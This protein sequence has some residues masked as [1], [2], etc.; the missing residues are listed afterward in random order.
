MDFIDRNCWDISLLENYFTTESRQKN[1]SIFNETHFPIDKISVIKKPLQIKKDFISETEFM[2]SIILATKIKANKKIY[3]IEGET[4]SGKSELC[5]WIEYNLVKKHVPLLFTR[6]NTN[7]KQIFDKLSEHSNEDYDVK[8]NLQIYDTENLINYIKTECRLHY[9]EQKAK[10]FKIRELKG[11][12]LPYFRKIVENS[13]FYDSIKKN[14]LDYQNSDEK[15]LKSYEPIKTA[16]LKSIIKYLK[17]QLNDKRFLSFVAIV[18]MYLDNLFITRF[19]CSKDI[20]EILL[21]ICDKYEKEDKRIVLIFEDITSM[22]MYKDQIFQFIFDKE[23][24]NVD[25]IIGVTTGFVRE[26]KLKESTYWDRTDGYFS[27]SSEKG[28]TYFLEENNE[29]IINLT[30]KYMQAV[31]KNCEKCIEKSQCFEVFGEYLFP[32]TK[33]VLLKI[34]NNLIENNVPKRTPRLLLEKVQRKILYDKVFPF[35]NSFIKEISGHF[36]S[37]I[38][39]IN[40]DFV[41]IFD[42]FGRENEKDNEIYYFVDRNLFK[43]FSFDL[44]FENLKQLPLEYDSKNVYLKTKIQK[45]VRKEPKIDT[46]VSVD[47]NEKL[48]QKQRENFAK[49]MQDGDRFL[50]GEELRIGLTKLLSSKH[51][52]LEFITNS[53]GNAGIKYKYSGKIP[54]HISDV[55]QLRQEKIIRL[56]IPR[57]SQHNLID[58][59]FEYGI[60]SISENIGLNIDRFLDSKYLLIDWIDKNFNNYNNK[61]RKNIESQGLGGIN[62]EVFAIFMK[63]LIQNIFFGRKMVNWKNLTEDLTKK[64]FPEIFIDCNFCPRFLS[65]II[66]FNCYNISNPPLPIDTLKLILKNINLFETFFQIV[67]GLGKG[68]RNYNL[69]SQKFMEYEQDFNKIE[70]QITNLQSDK[71]NKNI[72]VYLPDKSEISLKEIVQIV[73]QAYFKLKRKLDSDL[74]HENI[75][76]LIDKLK[77]ILNYQEGFSFEEFKKKLNELKASFFHK[78]WKHDWDVKIKLNGTDFIHFFNH[79]NLIIELYFKI[80]GQPKKSIFELSSLYIQILNN[81]SNAKEFLIFNTLDEIFKKN[82]NHEILVNN[83]D[84]KDTISLTNNTLTSYKNVLQEIKESIEKL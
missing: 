64:K 65:D 54:L 46:G 58:F 24:G 57:Q 13:A 62:L 48:I 2:N 3:I 70:S 44:E 31:K 17:I 14:L 18:K 42:I 61:I 6:T 20:V 60:N 59:S 78:D 35:N 75:S 36:L 77:R 52:F 26:N 82:K 66:C 29:N 41:K 71:I 37:T 47:E 53:S 67:F 4:G 19:G 49:W 34:Y 25:I 69:L 21:N 45:K 27:L 50:Y 79:L 32:F 76:I 9:D 81:V 23:I 56:E 39:E 72:I 40:P 83:S 68:I 1:H 8:G 84:F 51:E 12:F 16:Q 55:D 22:G 43:F 28:Y 10:D 74:I 5:Q 30:L 7:I 11:N 80:K 38:R 15:L 73:Q 33:D 63:C